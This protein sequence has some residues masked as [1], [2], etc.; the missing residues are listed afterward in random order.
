MQ[1]TADEQIILRDL[2]EADGY[3]CVDD[4]DFDYNWDAMITLEKAKLITSDHGGGWG[5]NQ[6]LKLTK[7]GRELQGLPPLPTIVERMTT[8]YRSMRQMA[9]SCYRFLD[10]LGNDRQANR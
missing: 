8:L 6:H 1:L 9:I 5:Y 3:L 10:G 4:N 7:K 2:T